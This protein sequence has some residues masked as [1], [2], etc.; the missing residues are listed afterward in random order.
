M[1]APFKIEKGIPLPDRC[2]KSSLS[3]L[4]ATLRGLEIGD[5]FVVPISEA[6]GRNNL[7]ARLSMDAK[8]TGRNYGTRQV[9]GG[10]RVWR[11]A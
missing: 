1:N 9:E 8:K 5:S 6:K 4:I 3:H 2:Y 11:V 7:A 10:Y